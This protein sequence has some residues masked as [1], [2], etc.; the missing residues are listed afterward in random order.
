MGSDLHESLLLDNEAR[1]YLGV[2]LQ[3][4]SRA[5]GYEV[6]LVGLISRWETVVK[7]VEAGYRD[8]IYE[9]VNDL[10]VRDTL[11]KLEVESPRSLAAPLTD[12]LAPLDLRFLEATETAAA[13]IPGV[14]LEASSP[15]SSRIP[16]KAEG[17]LLDDLRVAGLVAPN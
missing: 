12:H 14:A 7:Q 10:S 13:P 3:Q 9:Y 8:S 4:L 5:A 15:W 11:R 6:S 1:E 2:T 17:E 16:R